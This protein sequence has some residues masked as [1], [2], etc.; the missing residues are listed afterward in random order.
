MKGIYLVGGYPDRESFVKGLE[1]V[2][3]SGVDFVEVGIPFNDPVADGPVIAEAIMKTADAGVSADSIIEDMERCVRPGIK[4]Y[5]MTYCHIVFA[6]GIRK[7]SERC[8]GLLSGI[9]LADL[10][11]RM[12]PFFLDR[13]LEVP[14]V[15]FA[16]LESREEDL[17]GLGK[18]GSDFIY[19]VGLRGI[20]GA[21][22]DFGSREMKDQVARL[23][24]HTGKKIVIGF[25][26]KTSAD[27]GRALSLGDGF[28]AGTEAVRRQGNAS[29]L[30]HYLGDL[31]GN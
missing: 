19:F 21:T 5:V 23:R 7:F 20:T 16:T 11:N 27:A 1:T 22:A 13:G 9:I 2:M 4:M 10:P 17:A 15:P 29:E 14:I 18:A 8:K 26:V 6:Y 25:G 12:H 24:S 28:V 3:D 30:R 31:L